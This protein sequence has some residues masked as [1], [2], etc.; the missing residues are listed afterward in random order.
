MT[1]VRSDRVIF[2]D[3]LRGVSILYI[4]GFWHLMTYTKVCPIYYNQLTVRT[5]VVVLGLFVFLSGYF[6]GKKNLSKND[7][8]KAFYVKRFL[9]IYPLYFVALLLFL[10]SNLIDTSTWLKGCLTI[11]MFDGPV[12]PTV[13]FI[14]ML[15]VFYLVAPLFI[16]DA[17]KNILR[18]LFL[19]AAI[20][21]AIA[22]LVFILPSSDPRILIY[23]PS[24]ILG[25]YWANH[26]IPEGG[27]L[28]WI[29]TALVLLSFVLSVALKNDP[30]QSLL[31]TP[32]AC[33]APLAIFILFKRGS[34]RLPN[35]PVIYELSYAGFVMFL[36]HKPLYTVMIETYFPVTSGHQFMYLLFFC[37]P[38]TVALSWL[39]QRSYDNLLKK[40]RSAIATAG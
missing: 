15:L 14:S 29:A 11:S 34:N 32:L 19:T 38:V 36:I 9:R 35:S 39:T 25:I 17:K 26:D 22:F 40:L 18:Y 33:F 1:K 24:F 7:S 3:L 13:W 6:L 21:G 4:V 37:L 12:P 10:L 27:R 5:T 2:A 30:E 28:C 8:I 20:W 31:S 16:L 23:F